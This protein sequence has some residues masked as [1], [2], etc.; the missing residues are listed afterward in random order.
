M[1]FI[2]HLIEM[3]A[4]FYAAYFAALMA[5]VVLLATTTGLYRAI[6]ARRARKKGG[7]THA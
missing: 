5:V 2:K 4:I 1:T 7:L 6:E 3:V